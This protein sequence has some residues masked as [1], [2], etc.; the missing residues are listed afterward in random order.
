MLALS[1]CDI[2]TLSFHGLVVDICYV[3]AFDNPQNR[4]ILEFYHHKFR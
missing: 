3:A 4:V 1:V 2:V